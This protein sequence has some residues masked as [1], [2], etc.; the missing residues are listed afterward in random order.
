M[1]GSGGVFLT[2]FRAISSD[3]TECTLGGDLIALDWD[4]AQQRADER[5]LGEKVIGA[6]ST[7]VPAEEDDEPPALSLPEPPQ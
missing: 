4:H 1:A 6:L 3:G 2:E 5:G 7:M